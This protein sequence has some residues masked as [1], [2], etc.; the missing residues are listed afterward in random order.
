[1]SGCSKAFKPDSPKMRGVA[2]PTTLY[3][4]DGATCCLRGSPAQGIQVGGVYGGCDLLVQSAEFDTAPA[5][6]AAL[7]LCFGG[8]FDNPGRL[9]NQAVSVERNAER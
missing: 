9:T 2:I 7:H 5:V 8:A 4:A 6:L 3:F 1:M